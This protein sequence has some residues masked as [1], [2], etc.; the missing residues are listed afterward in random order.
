MVLYA[1]TDF[2]SGDLLPVEH[3]HVVGWA[4]RP[5][6]FGNITFLQIVL[7]E[8]SMLVDVRLGESCRGSHCRQGHRGNS[9]IE[10]GAIVVT[11][12]RN[13]LSKTGNGPIVNEGIR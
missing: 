5:G 10:C 8:M 9:H 6:R 11:I 12:V 1:V 13:S 4:W 2:L 7:V 3:I